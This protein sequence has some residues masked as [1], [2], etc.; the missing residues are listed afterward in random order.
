[1]KTLPFTEFVAWCS[2]RDIKIEDNKWLAFGSG[3]PDHLQL[4]FPQ[5]TPGIIALATTLLGYCEPH[6]F[7]GSMFHLSGWGMWG[8]ESDE[9]G[10]DLFKKYLPENVSL[11][12]KSGHLF[13]AGESVQQKALLLVTLFFQWDAFLIPV[14]G[15]YGIAVS[16]DEIIDIMF[17]EEAE[18]NR[19]FAIL[20]DNW[21]AKRV[22]S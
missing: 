17:R 14:H 1:M 6:G 4:P 9:A 19:V 22:K 5:N 12:D 15:K 2:Q 13:E 3:C 10:I 18:L 20:K 21:H 8:D 7:G 16:H 11:I